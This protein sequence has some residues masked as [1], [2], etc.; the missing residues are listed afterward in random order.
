[1]QES[2]LRVV[3]A[4]KLL[5]KNYGRVYVEFS[6]PIMFN[7]FVSDQI[8]ESFNPLKRKEQRKELVHRLGYYIVHRLTEK[9][10]VMSTS[11]VSAVLLMNRK[12]ITEDLLISNVHWLTKEILARGYRVG[13]INEGSPSIAIRNAIGHL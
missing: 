3:K 7:K 4:S 1:M 13:S 6:E 10:V 12:G 2:L 5:K 11:I 8:T 9:V